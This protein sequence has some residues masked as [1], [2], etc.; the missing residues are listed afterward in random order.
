MSRSPNRG[1]SALGGGKNRAEK[2]RGRV[3]PSPPP[4]PVPAPTT[5]MVAEPLKG[6]LSLGAPGR[7]SPSIVRVVVVDVRPRLDRGVI[8]TIASGMPSPL[9][10]TGVVA[11]TVAL[12][13]ATPLTTIVVG[14][15]SASGRNGG[16][17]VALL[18]TKIWRR[19]GVV[20]ETTNGGSGCLDAD[21]RGDRWPGAAAGDRQQRWRNAPSRA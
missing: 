5:R 1:T 9:T 13:K 2:S 20:A 10:S 17:S 16:V 3:V 7:V 12:G 21:G 14:S 19:A 8:V 11:A 15:I 6:T 4:P 18:K